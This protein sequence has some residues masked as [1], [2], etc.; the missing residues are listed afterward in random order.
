M[1]ERLLEPAL[2]TFLEVLCS[3]WASIGALA[4][5]KQTDPEQFRADWAQAN[6]EAIVE[7]AVST[8]QVFVE[9]YGDGADCN[10]VGSRVWMPGVRSTHAVSC[11]PVVG[12]RAVDRLMGEEIT[13]PDG[14]LL[15]DRFACPTEEG[16]YSERPP[17][18][19]VL[20]RSA[21]ERE[22]LF[23]LSEVGFTLRSVAE[24]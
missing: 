2:R 20:T 16:W 11:Y 6:W 14:G 24:T 19:H 17:F 22:A 10:A 1:S 23:R 7:A 13:F 5:L 18:D 15:V 12:R 21:G 3:N 4:N 9:P 8:G